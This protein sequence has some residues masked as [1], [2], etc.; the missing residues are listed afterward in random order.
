MLIEASKDLT[1]TQD[2]QTGDAAK[3]TTPVGTTL[4]LIE[5]GLKTFTAIVKRVHRALKRELEILYGLNSRYL[6]PQV[7]FTFQDNEQAVAQQ[8][9]ARN[10]CDVVPVSDPNMATDMQRLGRAQ[11]LMSFLG[12]GL[13]D[14]E[15]I[16]R[17]LEA[18]GVADIQ[19]LMPQ[20]PPPPDAKLA[21]ESD[22]I[23]LKHRELDIKEA[24]TRSQIAVNE[25]NAEATMLQT[26]L[27]SPQL[28]MAIGQFIDQRAQEQL[29][30]GQQQPVHPG[31]VPGM[32]PQ[33]PNGGVPAIPPGPAGPPQGPMGVGP[34]NG[35]PAPDQGPPN[36]GVGVPGMG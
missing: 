10:D 25:A 22:K 35:P 26:F 32:A 31:N 30:N 20:G 4:A 9:Y 24:E 8:D 5:Q 28:A 34:G 33:P 17:V 15:I 1:A 11:F 27:Q 6:D 12:K 29:A 3:S 18:A 14:Q 23:D 2:I 16:K 7:Y 36:G 19:G 21:I 13:N